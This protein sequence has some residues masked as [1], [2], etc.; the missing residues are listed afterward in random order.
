M[1]EPVSFARM[2][3]AVR[4]FDR[5]MQKFNETVRQSGHA[6]DELLRIARRRRPTR[7]LTRAAVKPTFRGRRHGW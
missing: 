4:D 5:S 3:A 7:L 2:V 6:F 1:T